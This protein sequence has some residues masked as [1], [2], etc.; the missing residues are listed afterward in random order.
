MEDKKK[1]FNP[2]EM[3]I[4]GGLLLGMGVGFFFFHISVFY[5]VGCMFSGLG[6]GLLF[7]GFV[8]DK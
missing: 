4:G 6:L 1:K 7:S 5:F 2:R 8:P 3:V